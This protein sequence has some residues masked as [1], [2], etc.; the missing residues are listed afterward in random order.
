MM[1]NTSREIDNILLIKKKR[2]LVAVRIVTVIC[3]PWSISRRQCQI[4][5]VCVSG[6]ECVAGSSK[7]P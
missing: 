5:L 6:C 7:E 2:F 1:N 3:Y 4:C